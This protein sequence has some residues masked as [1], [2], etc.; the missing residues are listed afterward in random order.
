[1]ITR[2]GG[3]VREENA[4]IITYVHENGNVNLQ[5]FHDAFGTD[6]VQNIE[7]GKGPGQWEWPEDYDE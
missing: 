1:M 4:A 5:V 2:I 6:F 7:Q 3:N